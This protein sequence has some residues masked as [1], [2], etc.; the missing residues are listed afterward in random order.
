MVRRAMRKARVSSSVEVASN[1][2]IAPKSKA[3]CDKGV[4]L[5]EWFAFIRPY[6]QGETPPL[7]RLVL[8]IDMTAKV[9][10]SEA[11]AEA[12]KREVDALHEKH[13]GR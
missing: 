3:A 8:G 11:R 9:Y 5:R 7:H 4:E 1:A 6:R 10:M 2:S 13:G 12:F